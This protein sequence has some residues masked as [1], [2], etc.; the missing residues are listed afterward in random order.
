MPDFIVQ[1]TGL[2]IRL[3]TFVLTWAKRVYFPMP[4][5][6]EAAFR[7]AFSMETLAEFERATLQATSGEVDYEQDYIQIYCEGALM[8]RLGLAR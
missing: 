6:A 2:A 1:E 5:E 7:F 4:P 3:E 8:R